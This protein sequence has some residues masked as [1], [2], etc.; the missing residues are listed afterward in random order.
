[1]LC[2]H[3]LS[4]CMWKF[5]GHVEAAPELARRLTAL[6]HRRPGLW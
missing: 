2:T 6:A 5:L 4:L 3:R 1:M